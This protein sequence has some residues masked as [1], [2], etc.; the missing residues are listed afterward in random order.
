MNKIQKEINHFGKLEHIWF[1]Q[2][3]VA[4]Q[5]RYDNKGDTFKKY[6]HPKKVDKILEIGCGDGEFTKRLKN[7]GATVVATDITPAVIK[8]GKQNL[9]Y[10]GLKYKVDNCE[11]LSFKDNSFSIVCG[12]SILHHVN[13][14]KT[15]SEA[16]RVLKPGGKIFFTEPNLANPVLFTQTN[17]KWL[18]D[19]MEFSPGET[20]LLR[21]NVEKTL[22]KVGFSDIKV[23]NYDFLFPWIPDFLIGPVEKIGRILEKTPFIKEISGSLLIYAEK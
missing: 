10:K 1:G 19:R 2:K 14:K 8:R 20:P 5:K 18:R 13:L 22:K 9:T 6:C 3:T 7:I 15:L 16:H 12:V 23:K 17:I 11:K 4:G 21:K